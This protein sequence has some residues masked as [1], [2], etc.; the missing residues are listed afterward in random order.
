MKEREDRARE[1]EGGE[2]YAQEVKLRKLEEMLARSRT[3]STEKSVSDNDEETLDWDSSA[4]GKSSTRS[5]KRLPIPKDV[6]KQEVWRYLEVLESVL[7]KN[8]YEEEDWL[9]ALNSSVLPDWKPLWWAKSHIILKQKQNFWPNSG[10]CGS[11][12]QP[13]PHTRKHKV[14]KLLEN[15]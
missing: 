5:P 8:G 10:R 1:R 4:G 15:L 7:I 12:K 2:K 11:F 3:C 14:G 6:Q 13:V 9:M